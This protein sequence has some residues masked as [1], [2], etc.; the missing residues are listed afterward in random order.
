MTNG[1]IGMRAR[2]R[3]IFWSPAAMVV[4]GLATRLVVM[5]FAYPSLLDPAR[6]HYA[7]GYEFGRIARSIATGQGFSSPYPEPTGPSALVGPVYAYLLA[8][9]FKLFGVYTTASALMIL[10]LNNVF[11][12]LICLP[13]FSIARRVFGTTVAV[14]AGWA[15]ALYPYSI[16]GSNV[17]VWET[18]LTSLLLTWILQYTLFLEHS[19]SYLAWTGYGLLWSL[20]ALTSAATLSTLPFLG[21]W[22]LVRQ[23]RNGT[24]CA[25]PVMA[26]SLFFL[27]AVAPWIWRC[28]RTY[29]RFVAFRGN[30]GL[31]VMV[32]NSDDTSNPSNWKMLPGENAAELMKLQRVGEPAYMAEKERDAKDVIVNHTLRFAGQTLRRVLYTWTDFWNFPPRWSLDASG[33]PDVLTYS[34]ISFLAFAGLGWSIR[35]RRDDSAP[36]MI[37]LVFFPLVY[38]LTHQDVRFRHPIDPVVVIF[39]VYGVSSLRRQAAEMP[40]DTHN[41]Y[42]RGG[43]T[44][45]L[46][47]DSN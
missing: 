33:V 43:I 26:A 16:A 19:S 23:R 45:R 28:S 24:R 7:F 20:A 10:T 2:A 32:G 44:D 13:V 31:E 29:G 11:S 14:W 8:G 36:L 17:W 22:I 47:G 38:Y 9:V 4:V 3:P 30:A 39:A 15:W 18:I 5:R 34:M 12:S 6:D 37:L 42:H 40:C 25:G 27:V 46:T 41:L 21:I 1:V 35:N